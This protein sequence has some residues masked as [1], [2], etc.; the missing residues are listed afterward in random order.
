MSWSNIFFA[1]DMQN[2]AQLT[3]IYLAEMFALKDIISSIYSYFDKG[4]FCMNKITVPH[5]DIGVDHATE[6]ENCCLKV[7]EEIKGIATIS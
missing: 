4:H 1:F 6:H 7:F 3:P 5:L 2:Y